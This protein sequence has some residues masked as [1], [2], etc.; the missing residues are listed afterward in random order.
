MSLASNTVLVVDDEPQ[1]VKYFQRAFKGLFPVLTATSA[2][3]AEQ[4]IRTHPEIA[5][6]VTDQRMPGR[7]GVSLLSWV[8][9]ERPDIIRILTTAYAD[10]DS[11]IEAVNRGE[12]FRYVTKPWDL[13]LLEAELKQALEFFQLRRDRQLLLAEKLSAVGRITVRDRICAFAIMAERLGHF[14]NAPA[15]V[16]RHVQ[17]ALSETRWARPMREQWASLAPDDH[18]RIPASE[19]A[20]TVEYNRALAAPPPALENKDAVDLSAVTREQLTA[21]AAAIGAAG[22]TVEGAGDLAS[23][24]TSIGGQHI[25]QLVR[26]AITRLVGW[27]APGAKLFMA[28]RQEPGTAESPVVL[29]IGSSD[30]VPSHVMSDSPL[31][32]RVLEPAPAGSVE[33]LRAVLLAGHVGAAFRVLPSGSTGQLVTIEMAGSATKPASPFRPALDGLLDHYDRWLLGTLGE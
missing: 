12:V 10:L 7:T 17:D 18:W 3:E 15:A 14:A 27:S 8:R 6:V 1:A 24:T 21:Q 30:C 5:V 25:G 22:L 11:A 13:R 26:T 29:S 16:Y 19:A 33:L 9:S 2:D 32:G 28:L 4:V 31:F 23:V 20:R